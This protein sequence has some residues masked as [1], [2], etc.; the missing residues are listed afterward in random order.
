MLLSGR[1]VWACRFFPAGKKRRYGA[2]GSIPRNDGMTPLEP[3]LW[4][5]VYVSNLNA[6]HVCHIPETNSESPQASLRGQ[7]IQDTIR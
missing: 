5:S 7:S 3:I 1:H 2:T 6:S 4:L